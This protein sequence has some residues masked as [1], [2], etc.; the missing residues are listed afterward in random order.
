MKN[1]V[2]SRGFFESS[3]NKEGK[4]ISHKYRLQIV[5]KDT[6]VMDHSTDLMWQQ[7]GSQ[8]PML[9]DEAQK[10]IE[11][12][13]TNNFGG[14]KDWRLPTL[15]E[16][17][18]LMEPVQKDGILYIDPVFS[19]TQRCILTSDMESASR[20]WFVYFDF[21]TCRLFSDGS[22]YVRA[23]RDTTTDKE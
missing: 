6:I 10:Y 4:G 14:R 23:V 1:M 19:R 5:A 18:S 15:E 21:G 16:A 22:P 3:E 13:N 8:Y 9:Y 20:D 17:M 11:R 2:M 12:L 7:G